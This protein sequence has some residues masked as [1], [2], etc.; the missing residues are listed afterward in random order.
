MAL[1]LG[2][3]VDRSEVFWE[4]GWKVAFAREMGLGIFFVVFICF[5]YIYTQYIH[6]FFF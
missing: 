6:I 3:F 4:G 2:A 1:D 5:F